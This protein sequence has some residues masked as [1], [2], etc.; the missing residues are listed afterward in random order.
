ME[1]ELYARLFDLPVERFHFDPWGVAPPIAAPLPRTIAEPYVVAIGGEARDYETLAAVAKRLP[2]RRFVAVVRPHSF[3]NIEAPA[4][5]TILVNL[6]WDQTWSLA[7]HADAMAIPLR[8]SDT[9]N[10]IVT[11]VGAA[12]LGKAMVVTDSSGIRDYLTSEQNSLLV[13]VQDA[14]AFAAAIERL[15][16]EPDLRRRLGDVAQGFAQTHCTEEVSMRAT[17]R[18][19]LELTGRA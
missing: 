9:P 18:H 1:R 14:A 7:A 6:P 15:W 19:I 16:D 2:K 4:N 11:I 17:I 10:G 13:P 12:H 8:S 3:Q 5:L